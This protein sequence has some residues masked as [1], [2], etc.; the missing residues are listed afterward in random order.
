MIPLRFKVS[1]K[2]SEILPYKN[3]LPLVHLSINEKEREKVRALLKYKSNA[4]FVEDMR[5]HKH[6]REM[7]SALMFLISLEE[8]KAQQREF[9]SRIIFFDKDLEK[10]LREM[11]G[12]PCEGLHPLMI[13]LM[14]SASC[15][16]DEW[17]DTIMPSE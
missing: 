7:A 5:K 9:F 17:D 6:L 12:I 2:S 4:L 16:T 8:D 15:D 3:L 1:L 10:R 11:F 14:Y 13:Q